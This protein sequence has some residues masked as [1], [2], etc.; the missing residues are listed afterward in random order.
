[1]MNYLPFLFPIYKLYS[2]LFI[3]FLPICLSFSSVAFVITVLTF[4]PNFNCHTFSL[5]IHY[6]G[7]LHQSFG[8]KI[9][10]IREYWRVKIQVI[11]LWTL[12]SFNNP[13]SINSIEI[14]FMDEFVNLSQALFLLFSFFRTRVSLFLSLPLNIFIF[15]TYRDVLC[16]L[17]SARL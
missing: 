3:W 4:I 9:T 10:P 15:I 5:L 13:Q 11:Q 16:M 8:K 2:L 14:V 17:Q 1:M 7:K 6:D 12:P